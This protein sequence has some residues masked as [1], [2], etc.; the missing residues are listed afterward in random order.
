[1]VSGLFAPGHDLMEGRDGKWLTVIYV[2]N[3]WRSWVCTLWR[4]RS[5]C[6]QCRLVTWAG[7]AML[8]LC[9]HEARDMG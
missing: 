3:L 5:P 9:V 4:C 8:C 1:M 7:Y 2:I 6:S